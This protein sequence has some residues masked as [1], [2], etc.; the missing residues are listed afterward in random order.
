MSYLKTD[1]K[2]G[3]KKY[4]PPAI[5][6]LKDPKIKTTRPASDHILHPD[7]LSDRVTTYQ[8]FFTVGV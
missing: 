7:R 3:S 8:S 5:P 2:E 6:D 4:K 1:R